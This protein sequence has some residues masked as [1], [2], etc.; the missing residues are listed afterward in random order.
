MDHYDTIKAGRPIKEFISDLSQWY[1]RRS[2]DR[3]K[4]GEEND[5]QNATATLRHVLLVLS[6]LMAPFTP[7]I[8]EKIYLELGGDKE[9]VHLEDWPEINHKLRDQVKIEQMAKARKIVEMGLSLRAEN[10]L[11]V[12]QPLAGLLTNAGLD[13]EYNT[14]VA[15]ELNV[16]EIS[17]LG[18][19]QNM[20][21]SLK[22]MMG[23]SKASDLASKEEGD[24]IVKLDTALTEELK[25]E[26]L[27]REIIR[28]V[29]Q[30]RKEQ[31][32]SI[33]KKAIVEYQTE[34]KILLAVFKE[35]VEILKKNTASAEFKLGVGEKEI[36][37]DD[38]ELKLKVVEI[39]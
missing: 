34:D 33:D 14:I 21:N 25:K 22:K 5:K 11:K 3:F 15:E 37:I 26:G 36:K 13:G 31:N 12:R 38:C 4:V 8:A 27:A 28:A 9:S 35:Q 24:L 23:R 17:G 2:R 30:I 7:F 39:S 32:L 1:V 19:K 20:V 6:K 10:S 18:E 16:K 29:N